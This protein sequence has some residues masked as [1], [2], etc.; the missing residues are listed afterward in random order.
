MFGLLTHEDAEVNIKVANASKTIAE[1]SRR[2]SSAMKTIALMTMLFL[3]GTFYAALFALPTLK[4]DNDGPGV[5]QREFWVFWAFT[6]PSTVLVMLMSVLLH[7]RKKMLARLSPLL[8]SVFGGAGRKR[9]DG[10]ASNK[11]RSRKRE[12]GQDSSADPGTKV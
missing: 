12:I 11:G 4:W 5:I 9:G 2:D 3:P 7:K 6:I 8:G 10:E 1:R